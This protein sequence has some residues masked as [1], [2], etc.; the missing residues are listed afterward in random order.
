MSNT[1]KRFKT[2]GEI[3]TAL[4]VG[5]IESAARIV[6]SVNSQGDLAKATGYTDTYISLIG[7]KKVKP[8]EQSYARI[9]FHTNS[10][11]TKELIKAALLVE[12]GDKVTEGDAPVK[13]EYLIDKLLNEISENL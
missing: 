12:F 7:N 9:L 2:V 5:R 1:R 10:S 4:R 8:S 13:I 3:L 6:K 11:V